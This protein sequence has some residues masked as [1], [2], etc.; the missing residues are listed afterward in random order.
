M[1]EAE[2]TRLMTDNLLLKRRCAELEDQLMAL[3]I[4][5]GRLADYPAAGRP[6]GALARE[7]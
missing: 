6:A 3:D 5:I 1:T 7:H 4:A 2:K